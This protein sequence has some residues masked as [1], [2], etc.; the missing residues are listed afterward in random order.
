MVDQPV[1]R[2]GHRI[3]HVGGDRVGRETHL[4]GMAFAPLRVVARQDP[5][6]DADRGRSCRNVA[7]YDGIG[8][9]LGAISH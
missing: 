9:Y 6:G 1:D 2:L 5:G 4:G 7:H 3:V 8:A